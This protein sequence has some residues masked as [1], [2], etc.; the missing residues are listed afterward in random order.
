MISVVDILPLVP[1]GYP[2]R[3]VFP[4]EARSCCHN[5]TSTSPTSSR[6]VYLSVLENGSNKA[7]M[8]GKALNTERGQERPFSGESWLFLL[9]STGFIKTIRIEGIAR[10]LIISQRGLPLLAP[11][12]KKIFLHD[13]PFGIADTCMS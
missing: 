11:T 6:V 3:A 5:L 1:Q 13:E 8:S 2:S 9:A 12:R 7:S 4:K 10:L